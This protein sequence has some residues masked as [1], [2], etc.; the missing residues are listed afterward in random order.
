MANVL[1]QEL[2]N[3]FTRLN[4]QEKKSFVQ[5]LKAFLNNRKENIQ[6]PSL[7]EYTKELEMA[8]AEIEVGD[9]I[10]HK[11]VVKYFSKK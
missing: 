8:D 6:V 4:E 10:L 5:L 11:D 1:E 2:F 7:E 3:Y 9:Y